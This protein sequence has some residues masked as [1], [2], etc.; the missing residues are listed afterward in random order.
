MFLFALEKK[1]VDIWRWI[2][3]KIAN[4]SMKRW[5]NVEMWRKIGLNNALTCF[6]EEKLKYEDK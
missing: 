3:L 1:K 4:T 2:S 6:R 5:K